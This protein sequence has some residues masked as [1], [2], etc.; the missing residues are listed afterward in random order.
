VIASGVENDEQLQFLRSINCELI[1]GHR[2]CSAIP[3]S[4]LAEL[5]RKTRS[6]HSFHAHVQYD[7]LTTTESEGDI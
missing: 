1:Q 7:L 3:S 4:E 6:G 5:F 2:L